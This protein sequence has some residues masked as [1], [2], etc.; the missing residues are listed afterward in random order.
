MKLLAPTEIKQVTGAIAS[1]RTFGNSSLITVTGTSTFTI[2]ST[3]YTPSGIQYS[4]GSFEEVNNGDF[5]TSTDT[6]A[7]VMVV[8]AV[9]GGMDYLYV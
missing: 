4:D 6:G 2:G 7:V 8:F 3:V 5:F 1:L 9:D